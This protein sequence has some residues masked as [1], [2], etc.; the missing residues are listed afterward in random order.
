[1]KEKLTKVAALAIAGAIVFGAGCEGSVD[2][3]SSDQSCCS[4]KAASAMH[5]HSCKGKAACKMAA[6]A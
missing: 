3:N 2:M 1:M 5:H 6:S 4:T